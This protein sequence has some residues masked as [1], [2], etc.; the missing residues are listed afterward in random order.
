LDELL[1]AESAE[2]DCGRLEAA[3]DGFFLLEVARAS[4]FFPCREYMRE[5]SS[6]RSS[7]ESAVGL[8]VRI[9]AS[10][11]SVC[12][13]SDE[14][15]DLKV[16]WSKYSSPRVDMMWNVHLVVLSDL[17]II[18][19]QSKLDRNTLNKTAIRKFETDEICKRRKD[20]CFVWLF[21]GRFLII[22]AFSCEPQKSLLVVKVRNT[23]S[24]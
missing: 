15:I 17:E 7:P 18:C 2:P 8:V 24:I 9:S 11:V 23:Q 3:L 20:Y 4:F 19:S 12:R 1:R 16:S 14:M 6:S 22:D 21:C 5:S 13:F 10:C